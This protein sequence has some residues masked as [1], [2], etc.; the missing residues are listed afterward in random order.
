M[1][2]LIHATAISVAGRAVLI[3]GP[4]GF[5]KSDLAL[6]CLAVTRPPFASEPPQ[7]VADDQVMAEVA[8]GG[9]QL[10][11]PASIA[12][13]IEVRGWGVIRIGSVAQA[14]LEL[15][16][17]LVDPGET[18]RLPDPAFSVLVCG[19]EFPALRIAPF[20]ASAPHKL[21]LALETIAQRTP[22]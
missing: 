11:P 21:L 16:A 19:V 2:E 17:D 10:R 6:R 9:V 14:R 12:G 7:L 1:A 4:S 18:E 20:E 5:G 13:L 8:E 15:V 3:R 22:G